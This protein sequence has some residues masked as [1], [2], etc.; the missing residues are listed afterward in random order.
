MIKTYRP[1][2]AASISDSQ[3]L[4][5][6]LDPTL[7]RQMVENLAR[8][9]DAY[10]KAHG[11][12]VTAGRLYLCHFLGMQGASLVLASASDTPLSTLLDPYAIT[13]NPFLVGHDA[14]WIEDWAD[15]KM[16]GGHGSSAPAL[17]VSPEFIGYKA[18]IDGLLTPNPNVST[19]AAMPG[20]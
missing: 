7:S 5:L 13:A 16:M 6:R 15:R 1:D 11:Q 14:A 2:L 12:D 19:V 4:D 9:G 18:A 8:E 10:L 17:V 3:I 20:A